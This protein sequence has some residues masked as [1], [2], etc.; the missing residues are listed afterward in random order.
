[1]NSQRQIIGLTGPAGAGKDTVAAALAEIGFKRT[2]FADALYSQVSINFGVPVAWLQNRNIKEKPQPDMA[3]VYCADADFIEAVLERVPFDRSGLPLTVDQVEKLTE[4]GCADQIEPKPYSEETRKRL[5]EM[6]RSPRQIL[7]WWGT[8][9][10]RAQCDTY[11]TDKVV[12]QIN[13]SGHDRW[14]ITDVRFPNEHIVLNEL[15]GTL[16]LITRPGVEAV[17]GHVSELFW[18]NCTPNWH[19]ENN[20]TLEDLKKAA[21]MITVP[22]AIRAA[23]PGG[24]VYLDL[25]IPV[26]GQNLIPMF[27][28]CEEGRYVISDEGGFTNDLTAALAKAGASNAMV[29]ESLNLVAGAAEDSGI[30][31]AAY[32]YLHKRC[33]FDEVQGV[34]EAMADVMVFCTKF[35]MTTIPGVIQSKPSYHPMFRPQLIDQDA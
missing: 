18:Q 15:G 7:Q 9:Y 21:P 29:L 17:S 12:N 11:W 16:C 5:V 25:P 20:G 1:M 19:L 35:A 30:E 33:H 31:L 22:S 6:L 13:R 14:V 4:S 24:L 2:A 8:E 34:L 10:R 27:I 32:R 3:L 26:E 23:G 28:R